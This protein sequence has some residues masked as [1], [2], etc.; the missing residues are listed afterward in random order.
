[1]VIWIIGYS[2]SGKTTVARKLAF[3]LRADGVRTVS[4]DGDDLRAILAPL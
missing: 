1:M 4:L 3:K 2:A